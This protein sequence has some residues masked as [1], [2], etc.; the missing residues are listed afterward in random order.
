MK[1]YIQPR[2]EAISFI[3]APMMIGGSNIKAGDD[4]TLKDEIQS[5]WSD[6]KGQDGMFGSSNYWDDNE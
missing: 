5:N 6:K 1:K 4:D 3:T 2:V